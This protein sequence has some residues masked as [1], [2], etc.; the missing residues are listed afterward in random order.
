[1]FICWLVDKDSTE[2]SRGVKNTKL[3]T[4]I[5]NFSGVE[6]NESYII[7]DAELKEISYGQG[8]EKDSKDAIVVTMKSINAKDETIYTES[9]WMTD[10]ATPNSKLGSFIVAFEDFFK[11]DNEKAS[12]TN[13]W[14]N[15]TVKIR[16]W[17]NKKREIEVMS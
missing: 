7:Q 16:D 12:E 8:K 14:I 1:M 3:K 2:K 13:N 17:K 15:H 10:T 5:A 4:E 11:G 6:V 9:L